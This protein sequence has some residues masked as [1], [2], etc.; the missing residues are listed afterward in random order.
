MP[1]RPYTTRNVF[2]HKRAI[3]RMS[4]SPENLF[5]IWQRTSPESPLRREHDF[6][7]TNS[8][9]FQ[10]RFIAKRL[11]RGYHGDHIGY[12]KFSRWYMPEKLPAIHQDASASSS[13]SASA[14]GGRGG[15]SS[16]ELN[17]WVEGRERSGGR[18]SDDKRKQK[19]EKDSKA[20]IGTM[21]FADVERRLDVLI[22]RACFAQSVWEAR[23]YVVQGH[24]K[25]N[26]QVVKNPNV[27]LE[28]G[29]MFTVDPQ[30]IVMLRAPQSK[31][32]PAVEAEAESEPEAE[33][34]ESNGAEESEASASASSSSSNTPAPTSSS[35]SGPAPSSH[36]HLPPY[37]QPHLFIP[38]YILPSF[39]TCSAVYVRHPTARPGY[40]E[41]P[42]PY[43]AGG[44]L[45]S[46]GWEYFKRSAPRM[47]TKTDKW[48]NPWGGYG[49]K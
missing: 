30:T 6:T 8:T 14:S 46:L 47:R 33:T 38:A 34:E 22:F 24:V 7:R 31:P 45:M 10:L 12:T 4:W 48:P 15:G 21:L 37:A 49:K 17:K 29:D 20:P 35:S 19:K 44:E 25:L 11:I 18:T 42:S 13:A 28:P 27:M 26:G 1:L 40:S 5:N 32:T 16:S 23:R 43:D 36:F 3:P 41:I 39:L 2:N 9:P